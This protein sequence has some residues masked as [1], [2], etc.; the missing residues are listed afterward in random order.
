[1]GG[2][3]QALARDSAI[4]V[5]VCA[6]L[7]ALALFLSASSVAETPTRVLRTSSDATPL[8]VY[9]E[10]T[11]DT[12]PQ[13]LMVVLDGLDVPTPH[14]FSCLEGTAH[15]IDV[16]S[17]QSDAPGVRYVFQTWSD[18]GAQSHTFV[19]VA[20]ATLVAYFET[21]YYLDI[22]ATLGSTN[23]TS[24]WF[25]AGTTVAIEWLPPSPPGPSERT[26]F[27]QWVGAGPGSYSGIANPAMI[28]MGGPII[29]IAEG[30]REFRFVFDTVPTGLVIEI[31]GV[32]FPTPLA[33]W[34]VEGTTRVVWCIPVSAGNVTWELREWDDGVTD[35]PRVFDNVSGPEQRTCFYDR[36]PPFVSGRSAERSLDPGMVANRTSRDPPTAT[37]D[38]P[39]VRSD[40][41]TPVYARSERRTR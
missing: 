36:N 3:T 31:D 14:T 22:S 40:G 39:N 26:T 12:N 20:D 29:E 8:E 2:R 21:Q 7:L 37:L 18:G 19:C 35:N 30:V 41:G 33:V 32:V 10:I 11:L 6:S 15:T 1:M 25:P 5:V 13:G 4:Y 17:P 34:W 9:Y 23:P 38:P 16:P 24:A 27:K 28:M